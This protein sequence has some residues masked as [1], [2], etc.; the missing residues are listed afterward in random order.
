MACRV[1]LPAAAIGT[2]F[3]SFPIALPLLTPSERPETGCADLRW[4]IG[5]LVGH[6]LEH[7]NAF[8]SH[9]NSASGA[10][11]GSALRRLTQRSVVRSISI[12]SSG[13]HRF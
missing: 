13:K 5:L 7:Q 4:Q 12:N 9:Q 11:G 6:P 3:D 1:T 8:V 10:A 2:E